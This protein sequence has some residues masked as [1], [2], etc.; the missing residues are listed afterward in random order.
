MLHIDLNCDVGESSGQ[1]QLAMEERIL[2]Q[3]TSVSIACGVHAGSPDLMRRLVRLAHGRGV[4]VGAH[5]GFSDPEGKGRRE[6]PATAREVETLIVNQIAALAGVAALVGSQL[7]HVKPHGA[8]YNQAAK[9]WDLARAIARGVAAVDRRLVLFGLADSHLIRAAQE[10]G[11]ACA[12]EAFADR[13]YQADGTLVPR[14]RPGAVI[15]DQQVVVARVL[16]LVQ[17]GK[18]QS[19]DGRDLTLRPQTICV[20]GDTP[21]ADHLVTLI[22]RALDGAGV[23]V[24]AEAAG[25][26]G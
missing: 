13:A 18:V 21:G 15:T 7:R 23:V 24:R 16:R 9:D 2:D 3:V 14:D 5:P 26:N 11:M 25:G 1:A 12:A 8:L 17:E 20:H 6:I 4:A 19:G 22:R 10:L